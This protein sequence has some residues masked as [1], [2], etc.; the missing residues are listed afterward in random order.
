MIGQ[1]GSYWSVYV[2]FSIAMDECANISI[3]KYLRF[4]KV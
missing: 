4:I 3:D 2:Y 1:W